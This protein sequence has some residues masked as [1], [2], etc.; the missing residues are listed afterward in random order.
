MP[1]HCRAV[2]I[3]RRKGGKENG[4]EDLHL[5]ADRGEAG[6]DAG[7]VGEEQ[8]EELPGEQGKADEDERCPGDARPL[9]EKDG[10]RGDQEA[11]RRQLRRGE[12]VEPPFGGDE[13]EA[14]DHRGERRQ[15][16]V[17]KWHRA[18]LW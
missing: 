11:Q 10:Q 1:T 9:H 13:G 3:S 8:Q 5:L 7:D 16:H 6:R 14:P 4:K 15:H 18:Y 2:G 17:A 12:D